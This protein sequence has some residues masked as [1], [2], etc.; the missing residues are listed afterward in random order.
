MPT[1]EY[2]C[3]MCGHQLEEF[4]SIS[5]EP[6]VHCP[7]C[8]TDNLVRVIGTGAGLIFKGTG[9]Y[10][11]DYKKSHVS[12]EGGDKKKSSNEGKGDTPSP[13]AGTEKKP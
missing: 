9:F 13:G 11:T 6:L 2:Q 8:G 1:Y 3:K 7:K 12:H 4:Q 10:L 5:E